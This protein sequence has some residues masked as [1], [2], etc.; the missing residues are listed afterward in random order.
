MVFTLLHLRH[1]PI[2]KLSICINSELSERNYETHKSFLALAIGHVSGSRY[3]ARLRA[4]G[5]DCG[6][7]TNKIF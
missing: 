6:L 5:A 1:V 4:T 2:L 3:M 7:D